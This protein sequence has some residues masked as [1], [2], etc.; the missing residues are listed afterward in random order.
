MYEELFM[1]DKVDYSYDSIKVNHEK[2]REMRNKFDF[3]EVADDDDAGKAFGLLK[4]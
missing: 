4:I 3:G 1:Q 2:N